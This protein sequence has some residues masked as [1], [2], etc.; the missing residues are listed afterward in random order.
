MHLNF[1]YF[2]FGYSL[3]TYQRSGDADIHKILDHLGEVFLFPF[4]AVELLGAQIQ[5]QVSGLGK[6]VQIRD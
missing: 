1:R 4:G 2:K 5:Y 3:F 6:D